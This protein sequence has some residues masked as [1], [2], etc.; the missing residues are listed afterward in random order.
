[1]CKVTFFPGNKIVEVEKGTTVFQAAVAAGVDIGGSCGGSG[2]CGKCKIAVEGPCEVQDNSHIS[3]S[4]NLCLGCKTKINGDVIVLVSTATGQFQI[5]SSYQN[6]IP[7]DFSPLVTSKCVR[8]AKPT[9]ENSEADFERMKRALCLENVSASAYV[10]RKLP[11]MLRKCDWCVDAVIH[12]NEIIDVVTSGQTIYGLAIDIGTTTIAAELVNLQNKEIVGKASDYNHQIV[13]GDDVISRMMYEEEYGQKKLTDLLL[14]AI[15]EIVQFFDKEIHAVCISGNTVM[16]HMLLGLPTNNIRFEPY[17][18]VTNFPPVWKAEEVGIAVTPSAPVYIV[19]GC[20]GY[21][22]GDITA[23]VVASKLSEHAAP[24]L[25]IDVGT[26]GEVVLGC[27]DW[28]L[29]CS[30]SAGP[31]F[32]GGGISCGMRG[33]TGAIDSVS[34]KNGHIEYTVIGD[35]PPEGVCGSGIIDAVAQMFKNGIIDKKGRIKE[36][37]LSIA[38]GITLTDDDVNNVI[39]TKAAIFA[40]CCV[41]MDVMGISFEELDSI[42]IAGGFGTYLNIENAQSIGLLPQISS[43]K[44]H[45][46]GNAA[47]NGASLCLLSAEERKKAERTA[48]EMTYVDLSSSNSFFEQYSSA[49]F[50]PHTNADMFRKNCI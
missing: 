50:I 1:M 30:T 17:V 2:S 5:S 40:G 28:I 4:D 35:V 6:V 24:S 46:I 43:E 41:L 33:I 37:K 18:P 48:R 21:V 31:S 19:P 32:E 49:L 15:N 25:L 7:A 36:G 38:E 39:R 8:L 29:T 34:V 44:Y 16:I 22:G 42:Y 10:L 23:G 26:N 3:K 11:E 27:Q 12:G 14:S 9:L 47:L 13:C 20:A 45:V